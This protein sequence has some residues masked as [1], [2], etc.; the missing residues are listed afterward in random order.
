MTTFNL[1]RDPAA[2]LKQYP[3]TSKLPTLEHERSSKASGGP[4][5]C[6]STIY[7]LDRRPEKWYGERPTGTQPD[8]TTSRR[9]Q[10]NYSS[11]ETN[12]ASGDPTISPTMWQTREGPAVGGRPMC[13]PK[14]IRRSV[15][16]NG[17][18][19]RAAHAGNCFSSSSPHARETT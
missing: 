3:Q 8:R 18:I 4:G 16:T 12:T 10:S 14:I 9:N 15:A 2:T 1:L 19:F 5:V 17:G 6:R 7:R 11:M 13:C